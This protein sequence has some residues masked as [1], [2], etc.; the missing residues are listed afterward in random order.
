MADAASPPPPGA[1]AFDEEALR[2]AIL[3]APPAVL[4]RLAPLFRARSRRRPRLVTAGRNELL[5]MMAASLPGGAKAKATAVHKAILRY[6]AATW[7]FEPDAPASDQHAMPWRVLKATGG[8]V[9]SVRSLRRVFATRPLAPVAK[10]R[11]VEMAT[12]THDTSNQLED[13]WERHG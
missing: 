5:W 13:P 9:P 3:A 12:A 6:S 2:R 4:E 11:A 1:L 7:R 10:N 8:K